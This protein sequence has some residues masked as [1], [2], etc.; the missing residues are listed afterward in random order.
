MKNGDPERKVDVD[1]T[2]VKILLLYASDAGDGNGSDHADWAEA[3]FVV[4]GDDPV[5]AWPD[6]RGL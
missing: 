4:D 2:G 6:V 5:I 3:Y 1:T